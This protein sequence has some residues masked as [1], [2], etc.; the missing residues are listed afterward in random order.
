[1]PTSD[2]GPENLA[3]AVKDLATKFD[4][5]YSEIVGE[6]LIKQNF[7]LIHAVGRASSQEPRLL[8]VKS[9]NTGP[10]VTLVGKGVCFDTGG[11]NIKPGRSMGLMKKDMGGAANVLALAYMIL[12]TGMNV[13][14]RVLIPAV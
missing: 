10:K 14:L 3:S 6:D 2:M 4:V 13:Q 8:E 7:P 1:M 12:S 9:G 5:H 11:L